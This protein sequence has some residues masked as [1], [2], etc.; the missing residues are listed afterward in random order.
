MIFRLACELAF[1]GCCKS[2][3]SRLTVNLTLV[4]FSSRERPQKPGNRK[5]IRVIGTVAIGLFMHF[6]W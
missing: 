6:I 1:I 4:R 5:L 3:R 2:W